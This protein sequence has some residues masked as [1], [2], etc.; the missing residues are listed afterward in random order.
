MNKFIEEQ[1]RNAIEAGEFD[2]LEGAGKPLNLDA[3]FNTP[4]DFRVGYSVLKSSK[5]VP[6]E[7]E[8][9]KEIGELREKLQNCKSEEE[10]QKINKILNEKN[11]AL[12]LLL[13]RNKRGR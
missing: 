9:L 1:L 7:V 10:K 13:E 2:N 5:F 11:L 3:Y 4:E 12:S 8:R 6:E